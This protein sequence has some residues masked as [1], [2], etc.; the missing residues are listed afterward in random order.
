M[1]VCCLCSYSLCFKWYIGVSQKDSD[2]KMKRKDNK[3][4]LFLSVWF[5]KG[6]ESAL[7]AKR[8]QV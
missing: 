2:F 4:F 8:V 7:D 1:F 5:Q 6:N 3:K